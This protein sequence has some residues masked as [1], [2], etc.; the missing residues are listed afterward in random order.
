MKVFSIDSKNRIRV[1]DSPEVRSTL[2]GQHFAS[3]QRWEKI[4]AAWPASRLVQIWNV[5][6][7]VAPVQRFASRQ[8]ALNRIWKAVQQLE[9]K[10]KRADRRREVN[11]DTG[12]PV[13]TL[14]S[15]LNI[16]QGRSAQVIGLLEAE[17]GASLQQ[18]VDATGWQKHSIR[19]FLSGTIRKKL[20]LN[21]IS[22]KDEDGCRIYRLVP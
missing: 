6:P 11:V 19:G 9:P 16:R 1:E 14:K 15:D 18:L 3:A 21:L 10:Q 20:G 13:E 7:E 2:P 12:A 8:A 22:S 5:L 17:G 4:A